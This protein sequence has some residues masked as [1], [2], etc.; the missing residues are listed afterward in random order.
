MARTRKGGKK[1]YQ[2]FSGNATRGGGK[3]LQEQKDLSVRDT[4]GAL[5]KGVS[6]R[7]GSKFRSGGGGY[8]GFME[9]KKT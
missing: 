6:K 3:R 8:I 5:K 4:G 7:K 9:R 2:K 1:K